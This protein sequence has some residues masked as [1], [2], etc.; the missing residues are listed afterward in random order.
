M[1]MSVSECREIGRFLNY[2]YKYLLTSSLDQ[3]KILPKNLLEI[4]EGK[5]G[6]KC[7]T[8]FFSEKLNVPISAWTPC[9]LPNL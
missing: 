5:C 2:K 8:V 9:E 1:T 7:E 3:L 4:F 6:R